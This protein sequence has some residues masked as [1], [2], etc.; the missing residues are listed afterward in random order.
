MALPE[1]IGADDAFV[2]DVPESFALV[3]Q[4]EPLCGSDDDDSGG[5]PHRHAAR[6]AIYRKPESAD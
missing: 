4:S 6:E 3:S 2:F 1:P 5:E